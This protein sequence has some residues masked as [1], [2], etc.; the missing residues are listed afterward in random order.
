VPSSHSSDLAFRVARRIAAR[1]R[2]RGL[3]QEGLAAVLD[4]AV[5]NVQRIESGKQNLSLSTIERISAALEITPERLIAGGPTAEQTALAPSALER[6]RH[7]GYAVRRATER[8]R[9]PAG[10]IPVTTL[11]AAAGHLAGVARAIE[12]LGWVVDRRRG[13]APE[14]QFVAEVSGT[15]MMP[16]IPAGAVCLFGRP[17]PPPIDGRIVLVAHEMLADDTL[18]GPYALKRVRSV[19]KRRDGRIQVV[20][21][22]VNPAFPPIELDTT[23]DELRIIAE[24]VRVLVP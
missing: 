8:G 19:K 2:E 5:K 1:R 10:S 6:L 14:G 12:V 11:R 17:A 16:A 24:L 21:E 9:R 3:S 23:E 7:G 4:I 22:S 13:P 20:L 15:S 18:G